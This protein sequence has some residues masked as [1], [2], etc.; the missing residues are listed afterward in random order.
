MW[1][2]RG[3]QIG[4]IGSYRWN[5][6][7]LLSRGSRECYRILD[8][9]L[10]VNPVP[11]EVFRSRVHPEDYPALEQ[12]SPRRSARVAIHPRVPR[13]PQGRQDVAC[14]GRRTIR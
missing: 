1:M 2:V 8:I 3:Q 9:D 11:F 12:T 6:R 4:G 7:T 13:G 10:D 14:R 5:T